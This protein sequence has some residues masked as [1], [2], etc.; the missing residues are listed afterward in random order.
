MKT[1][2]RDDQAS[3]PGANGKL[4]LAGAVRA[5]EKVLNETNGRARPLFNWWGG[6]AN[7]SEL[8]AEPQFR[9][10]YLTS[11]VG[12]AGLGSVTIQVPIAD[13]AAVPQTGLVK[14]LSVNGVVTTQATIPQNRGVKETINEPPSTWY[15][16]FCNWDGLYGFSEPSYPLSPATAQEV[17]VQ[18]GS[19]PGVIGP[20]VR[21][22]L[23]VE[24]QNDTT[25]VRG[26]RVPVI[27]AE[28]LPLDGLTTGND[29]VGTGVLYRDIASLRDF[30]NRVWRD[31]RIHFGWS[32]CRNDLGTLGVS[33]TGPS[34]KYVLNT[35]YGSSGIAPT[36]AGPGIAVPLRYSAQGRSTG[37]RIYVRV[38]ARMAGGGTGSLSVY[39]RDNAGGLSGP[40]AVSAGPAITGSTYQWWPNSPFF[41]DTDPFFF[42][43]ANP[44]YV[45]DHILLCG[46]TDG[47][48]LEIA[49]FTMTVRPISV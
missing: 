28:S 27:G 49:A 23:I 16:Q 33:I 14:N 37:V 42:G 38:F 46:S 48:A 10:M 13:A 6:N 44:L 21:S 17:K 18:V 2:L 3:A 24:M 8:A 1:T 47:S 43:N 31:K 36:L 22:G 4:A 19:N 7:T 15:P 26:G 12:R 5:A 25:A 40:T 39:N 11:S 41:S 9:G 35:A 32:M 45:S 20:Q 34:P 29:I 30:Y